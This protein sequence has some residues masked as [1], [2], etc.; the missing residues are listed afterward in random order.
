MSF[1]SQIVLQG[2]VAG[3]YKLWF[4]TGGVCLWNQGVFLLGPVLLG[5]DEFSL[6]GTRSS[7]VSDY[8][9]VEGLVDAL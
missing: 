4:V 3:V 5:Y 2:F 6:G 7:T 9:T 1:A 8:D